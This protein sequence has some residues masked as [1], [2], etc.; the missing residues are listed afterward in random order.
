MNPLSA[1]SPVTIVLILMYMEIWKWRRKRSK[2]CL[3]EYSGLFP[4]WGEKY[5]MYISMTRWPMSQLIL[6]I[7]WIFPGN[8]LSCFDRKWSQLHL[9]DVCRVSLFCASHYL[10]C[11]CYRVSKY[12]Y[13]ST[14]MESNLGV[15]VLEYFYFVLLNINSIR[16]KS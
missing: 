10:H 6:I 1:A 2:V 8:K 15:L 11:L 5:H 14:V 9:Q 4:L 7:M 3:R 16:K 12:I 13:S